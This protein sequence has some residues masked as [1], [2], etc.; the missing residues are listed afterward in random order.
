[1]QMYLLYCYQFSQIS[2]V[3]G[4]IID[5][6]HV[7]K[8]VYYTHKERIYPKILFIKLIMICDNFAAI[9]SKSFGRLA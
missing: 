9:K 5:S 1:M 7:Y 4:S 2:I 3:R 6:D 8:L